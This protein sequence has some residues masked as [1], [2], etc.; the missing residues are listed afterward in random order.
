MVGCT[1]PEAGRD[2][3]PET[4][5]ECWTSETGREDAVALMLD[6]GLEDVREKPDCRRDTAGDGGAG[7]EEVSDVTD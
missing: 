3:A 1:V 6:T 2:P 7:R 4:D 5:R